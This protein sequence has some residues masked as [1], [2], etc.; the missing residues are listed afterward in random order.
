MPSID[1]KKLGNFLGKGI[2]SEFA[3]EILQG[4]LLGMFRAEKLDIKKTTI[5]VENNTSLWDNIGQKHQEQLKMLAQKLGDIS[6]IDADWAINSLKDDF[7]ALASLFLGWRKSYNWMERQL[8]II[9]K[10]VKQ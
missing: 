7:P 3:P 1:V 4:V 2:V 5:W 10:Q 8:D 9:K 6:F